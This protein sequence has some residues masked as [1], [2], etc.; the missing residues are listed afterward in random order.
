MSAKSLYAIASIVTNQNGKAYNVIQAVGTFAEIKTPSGI[1]EIANS[2]A[3]KFSR[4]T[5]NESQI[6]ESLKA[7]N[8]W[9]NASIDKGKLGGN[10]ASLTRFTSNTVRPLVILSQ[11]TDGNS[12]VLGYR[13]IYYNGDVAAVPLKKMIEFGNVTTNKKGIPVQNAIFVPS[14]EKQTAHYKT[15]PNKQFIEEIYRHN[16]NKNTVKPARVTE[17]KNEKNLSSLEEIFTKEQI[18]ELKT[19]KRNGVNVRIYANPALSPEQMA[20]LRKGLEK[21]VDVRCLANPQFSPQLMKYYIADLKYGA[22]IKSY[23]NPEYTLA[24][25][26]EVST[27]YFNGL[28]ISQL[29]DPKLSARQ[30]E[31]ISTRLKLGIW[32]KHDVKDMDK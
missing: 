18:R 26:A 1:K 12:R 20:E 13:V 25:L 7:G 28:D 32:K 29:S 11:I 22:N 17:K 27:A 16:K 30:M 23:L 19:G 9:I 5:L 21:G 14:D 6:I 3:W 10:G 8:T 4:C 15:Y 2:E 24:Q 31:E